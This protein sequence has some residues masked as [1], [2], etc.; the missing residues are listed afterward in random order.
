MGSRL[1]IVIYCLLAGGVGVLVGSRAW[2]LY[3]APP[4]PVAAAPAA[5]PTGATAPGIFTSFA[6]IVEKDLPAVV[7]ISS[8]KVV[9]TTGTEIPFTMD[10]F[11]RQFFGD[12]FGRQMRRPSR[13]YEKGLG[14]GVV[15]RNDGYILTNNHV[16]D[17]ATDITVTLLDKRE[18]RAKV[19][20][21]DAKTDI[22]V[23]KIESKDLPTLA[24]ADSSKVRVGD[25]VLA[26]GQPFGLSQS[27]TMGIISAKGRSGL[28]IIQG[29]ED[30]IQTDAAIN[31]GNSGGALVDARGNLVGINT[32]I[33]TR[34]GGGNQG[35]GFAVPVN[36]ARSVMDQLIEHGRVARGYMGVTPE[37]ITSA[38]AKSFRLT[39][40][41]GV[42]IGDVASGSPA[43]QAG[44]QRGDVVT[45]INGDRVEDS[46]QLRL[47]ISMTP[48]GTTVHVKLLRDGAEKNVAVK[49][50]EVPGDQVRT[51]PAP[52]RDYGSNALD[53]VSV[54]DLD[55]QTLRQLGLP[56]NM[57]GVVVTQVDP[58]T[59]AG[60]A[61]LTPGDVIVEVDRARVA[62]VGDF[63]RAVRRAPGHTVL[64]L[65]NR[66]G[67]TL[68]VAIEPR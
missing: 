1:R 35:I 15:V 68:Y 40:M 58:G 55:Y 22:G 48:P 13:Q 3:F 64:L 19:V 23:L 29:Y 67:S 6:P 26:M 43:A 12:D 2:T 33:L 46:N 66:Q 37:D 50:S 20:G 39:D 41:R 38:M 61:G 34:N 65:V 16:V 25:V 47:K 59:S 27:V 49:L 60:E 8:S 31:P 52:S 62:S 9:R 56:S 57:K 14:S 21:T 7:N 18:F 45:E 5:T 42:L 24:F 63:E 44:I 53:G 30:F 4:V 54:Q 10:P 36:M 28:D 32:A 17:G 51:R 11:F